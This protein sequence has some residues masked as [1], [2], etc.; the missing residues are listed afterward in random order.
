M[1]CA[2]EHLQCDIP[3]AVR[4]QHGN[5]CVAAFNGVH[6]LIHRAMQ[7]E[8]RRLNVLP[9][10]LKVIQLDTAGKFPNAIFWL[11]RVKIPG[12]VF[13]ALSNGIQ[14]RPRLTAI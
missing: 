2:G 10:I 8:H 4:A 6:T 14:F 1:V 11:R 9:G 5:D 13:E 3:I 12:A 7:K